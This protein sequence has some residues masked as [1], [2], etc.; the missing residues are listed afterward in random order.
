MAVSD[1][2]ANVTVKLVTPPSHVIVTLNGPHVE[3]LNCAEHWST[4]EMMSP[5]TNAQF[6]MAH[7]PGGG[8]A[9][10]K[11]VPAPV[12]VTPHSQPLVPGIG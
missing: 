2:V 4:V 8:A 9:T 5:E 10:K 6:K 11:M 1:K 7:T 12:D 3:S